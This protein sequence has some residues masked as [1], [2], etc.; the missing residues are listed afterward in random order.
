MKFLSGLI[1]FL[2][3]AFLSMPTVV[4][5][6]EKNTDISVLYSFSEEEIQKDLKDIKASIKDESLFVFVD[7]NQITKTPIISENVAKH[8]NVFASIF[9]PPPEVA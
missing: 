4:S 3:I 5:L 1:L 7:W 8:D 9:S 2:F 6:I